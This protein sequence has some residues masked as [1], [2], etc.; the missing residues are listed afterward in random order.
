MHSH[1]LRPLFRI[2]VTFSVRI[3]VRHFVN[4]E[5]GGLESYDH[6]VGAWEEWWSDKLKAAGWNWFSFYLYF[7]YLLLFEVTDRRV[8]ISHLSLYLRKTDWNN[9]RE[10][11]L[12]LVFWWS[13][14]NIVI[15]SWTSSYAYRICKK[16]WSPDWTALVSGYQT[17]L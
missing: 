16:V 13:M 11:R 14:S 8:T 6:R 5:K 3:Y 15:I 12:F 17:L 4:Q 7:A 2:V 10:I 1:I 9:L